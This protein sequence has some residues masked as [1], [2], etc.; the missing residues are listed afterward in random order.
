MRYSAATPP[1]TSIAWML[2]S[3]QC[4]GLVWWA[5]DEVSVIVA[6]HRSRPSYE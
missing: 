3:T 6:T 5:P 4:A 1:V 2:A